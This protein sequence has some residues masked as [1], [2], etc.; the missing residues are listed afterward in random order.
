MFVKG[1]SKTG[2]F[3]QM[4]YL[5]QVLEPHIRGIL[6]AFAAVIH[7]LRPSVEPLFIEDSNSAYGYKTITNCYAR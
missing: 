6:E 7:T 1:T 3:K 2:A 4:D 5:A